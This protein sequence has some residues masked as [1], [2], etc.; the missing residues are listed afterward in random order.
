MT[1]AQYRNWVPPSEP[2]CWEL[3]DGVPRWRGY[4]LRINDFA[5]TTLEELIQVLDAAEAL[6]DVSAPFPH[7][8]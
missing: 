2:G 4:R 8:L 3:I 5:A 7:L 6:G 1:A